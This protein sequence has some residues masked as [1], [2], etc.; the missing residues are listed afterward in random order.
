MRSHIATGALAALAL[1][2]PAGAQ[3]SAV[4]ARPLAQWTPAPTNPSS[5]YL[6]VTYL[7]DDGSSE[8]ALGIQCGQ[9]SCPAPG[10]ADMVWAHAFDTTD[11]LFANSSSDTITRIDVAFGTLPGPVAPPVGTSFNVYLFEDPSDLG[12]PGN[13][14]ATDLVSQA[15]AISTAPDTDTFEQVSVPPGIVAGGFF[16]IVTM[17]HRMSTTPPT[18]VGEFPAAFDTATLSMGRA[19]YTGATPGGS[20]T[21][22]APQ[23]NACGGWFENTASNVLGVY[24]VR[25]AGT[26][27]GPTSFCTAKT[28]VTC[29]PAT[30]SASGLPSAT[31]ASGFTLSAAPTR[32]CRAGLLLYSNQ[33]I[34]SGVPFGGPGDGLLCLSP[35]GLRRAGPIESGGTSPAA[36]DGVMAIDMNAFRNLTWTATGCAPPA[37]QTQPAGF[38]GNIGTVV[39]TQIWGRDSTATGQVLSNGASYG[40]GP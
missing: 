5:A 3:N 11:P 33:P 39:H 26:G 30:I 35:M 37:G 19:W 18:G 6:A 8:N 7:F 21:P 1:A 27:S 9:P 25:A 15:S 31:A 23:V 32:G 13:L 20:W 12:N 14:Q 22:A 36:C 2:A 24:L 10:T 38:L 40:V 4:R 29:G 28:T 17:P 16:V 34:T